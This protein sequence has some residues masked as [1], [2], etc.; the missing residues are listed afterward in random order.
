MKNLNQ[1]PRTKRDPSGATSKRIRAKESDVQNAIF[2]YLAILPGCFTWRNNSVGVFDPI[3]KIYRKNNGKFSINGV[4]DI[5]G[6]YLGRPL[7]IE[8]KGYGGK[9]SPHQKDFLAKFEV[10]GG[11]LKI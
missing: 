11:K 5:L 10:A 3:K 6:I 1:R 8:V 9:L 2:E 7:A 4:A